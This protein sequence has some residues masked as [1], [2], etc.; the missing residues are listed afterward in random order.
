MTTDE[1]V[2]LA[3]KLAN[4]LIGVTSS[5]W[6]KWLSFVK[7]Q[8]LNEAIRMAQILSRSPSLRPGPRR[9]Y[10]A[11][12]GAVAR[13]KELKDLTRA[14]LIEVLGYATRWLI[15]RRRLTPGEGEVGTFEQQC[16]DRLR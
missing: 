9:S 12:R 5:E 3:K 15:S 4:Q 8:G 10:E 6:G 2:E 14:D 11:I 16:S 7:S 1:K 13:L